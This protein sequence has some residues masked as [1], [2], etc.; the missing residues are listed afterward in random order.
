MKSLYL[1]ILL[2]T[3]SVLIASTE[4]EQTADNAL[5]KINPYLGEITKMTKILK[6]P[7]E[8]P[9][10]KRNYNKNIH[11]LRKDIFNTLY[12]TIANSERPF[13]V[14]REAKNAAINPE[15]KSALNGVEK[16]LWFW[17]SLK[18]AGAAVAAGVVIGGGVAIYKSNS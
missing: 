14:L 7:L 10:I 3:P 4:A 6:G 1:G 15:T 2:A 8:A 17:W 11:N 5:L 18:V 9:D 12:G 13:A 16:W